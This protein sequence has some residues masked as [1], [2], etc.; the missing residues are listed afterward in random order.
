MKHLLILMILSL[1]VFSSAQAATGAFYCDGQEMKDSKSK[2]VVREFEREDECVETLSFSENNKYCE[3]RNLKDLRTGATI[4]T[5][6]KSRQCDDALF[7]KV[8]KN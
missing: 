8:S 2:K 6:D 3:S 1:T 5:F 4:Q 7:T